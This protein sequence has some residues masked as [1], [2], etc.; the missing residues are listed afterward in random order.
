MVLQANFA[1]RFVS[2]S[3]NTP[4]SAKADG[5]RLHATL[6]D[7]ARRRRARTNGAPRAS[8]YTVEQAKRRSQ[9][10]PAAPLKFKVAAPAPVVHDVEMKDA[11]PMASSSTIAD[12]TLPKHL[13]R[14]QFCEVSRDALIAV[15][16][17]LADADLTFIREELEKLGPEL[18]FI[19][20]FL[21]T[22]LVSDH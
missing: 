4:P 5:S 18:V 13:G 3:E 20:S 12:V 21:F 6:H 1:K 19:L 10:K 22:K 9:T 15:D 14:P 11:A 16:P 2:N 8:K 17:E 7:A